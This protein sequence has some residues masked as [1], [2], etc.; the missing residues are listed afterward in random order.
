MRRAAMQGLPADQPH[1]GPPGCAPCW[2][3]MAP[4]THEEPHPW[5]VRGPPDLQYSAP[6]PTAC[7][8][9]L[10]RR[11]KDTRAR[12]P[13]QHDQLTVRRSGLVIS[14]KIT[15]DKGRRP[16]VPVEL[17]TTKTNKIS[18]LSPSPWPPPASSAESPRD[19]QGRVT[20]QTCG[21]TEPPGTPVSGPHRPGA[22]NRRVRL[23]RWPRRKGTTKSGIRCARRRQC[24]HIAESPLL[25]IALPGQSPRPRPGWRQWHDSSST[26]LVGL[27]TRMTPG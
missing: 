1:G 26:G 11:S 6:V 22:L 15:A 4:G 18:G 17:P 2:G 23:A 9:Q 25:R 7:Q 5:H 3:G 12:K 24:R 8:A 20:G 10:D 21:S 27:L 16:V 13:K 14:K 19:G